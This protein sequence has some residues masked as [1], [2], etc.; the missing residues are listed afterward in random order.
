MVWQDMMFADS[1]YPVDKS[2]ME[3]VTEEVTQQVRRLQ[4]HAC[5]VV[6]NGNDENEKALARNWYGNFFKIIQQFCLLHVRVI[7]LSGTALGLN[8]IYTN[9]R[10]SSCT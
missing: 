7:I 8:T 5:I 2:F 10:I 6:W 4:H 3:S 9:S 1:M